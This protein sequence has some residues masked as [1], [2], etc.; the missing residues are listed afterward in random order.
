MLVNF[1]KKVV[2]IK[3]QKILYQSFLGHTVAIIRN[4]KEGIKCLW[5][6][7]YYSFVTPKNDMEKAYKAW[8]KS[9]YSP[10]P[11]VWKEEYDWQRYKVYIDKSNRL[12]YVIHNNKRLYFR[13]NKAHIEKVYRCLLI[14]QDR[15][16][17]HRYVDSYEELRGKT[18]LDIGASEGIFTLDVIE[19]IKHAYVI[20][21]DEAWS[22]ALEATFA[23]WREKVTIVCKYVGDHDNENSI[24]L[25]SLLKGKDIN[26]LFLKMDIEGCERKALDGAEYI[27]KNSRHICGSICVYHLTD[28]V[29]VITSK[30]Q[31]LNLIAKVQ[32][33]FLY[34]K[35]EMRP[36]IVKFS[37]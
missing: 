4:P 6:R 5:C 27:L 1:Y 31:R 26:N 15:R 20:G 36:A 24:K 28:D 23:P 34:F 29:E 25:D 13:R 22:E 11:Y 32:P 37:N 12:P 35:K 10:Y 30:L 3:M 7:I 16:S 17:A 2:P 33:G 8:G 18:L 14:E 9:G 21:C 19:Y